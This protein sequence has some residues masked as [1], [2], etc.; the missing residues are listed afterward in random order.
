MRKWLPYFEAVILIALIVLIVLNTK[1]GGAEINSPPAAQAGAFIE[2]GDEYFA[3][4]D[5]PKALFAYWEGIQAI[6]ADAHNANQASRLHAHLRIS[7]IYFH[8]NWIADAEIHLNRAAVI[9]PDH[10]TSTS[11]AESCCATPANK[12]WLS[13][14]PRC[15]RQR[16]KV[17][18]SA[19][20]V[21]CTVSGGQS[22]LRKHRLTMRRRS[23]MIPI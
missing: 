20:S 13:K 19:L 23:K 1:R 3:K 4:Q 11:S 15:N 7:E 6:E 18:G 2:K 14:I 5:L 8:S 10:P 17:R 21:R 22:S 12:H 9:D 16:P